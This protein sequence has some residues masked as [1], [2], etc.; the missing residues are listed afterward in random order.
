MFNIRPMPGPAPGGGRVPMSG[1]PIQAPII[2]AGAPGV[3]P[4]ASPMANPGSF[5]RSFAPQGPTM[6]GHFREQF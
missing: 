2:P 4:S 3:G 5:G 6:A 1:G